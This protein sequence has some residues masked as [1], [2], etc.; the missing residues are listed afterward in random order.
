MLDQEPKVVN[1]R[2]AGS[3][4]DEV[5]KT[6]FRSSSARPREEAETGTPQPTVRDTEGTEPETLAARR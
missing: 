6:V 3:T 4:L 2:Y 1:P 5:A